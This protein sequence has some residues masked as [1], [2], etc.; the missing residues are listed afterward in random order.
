MAKKVP[1]YI[2]G[3]FVDS[4]TSDWIE[5]TNPATNEVIAHCPVA[6]PE[7]IE[8]AI[9]S[10][11]AAQAEWRQVPV[12]ERARYIMR[13]QALL[14]EHQEDIARI[15]A[16]ETGKIMADAMGDVWRGIE[17]VEHAMGIPTLIM[18]ETV[19][20]VAR[21]VDTISWVHPLGVCAGITPFNFPA[22]IPLWMFPLAVVCG[23]SF[24][25]K[26]SEQ[27]PL[28]PMRLAELW[29]EAGLP[30]GL[31]QIVHGRKEQVEQII[32]HPDIKAVSFVGSAPVGAHIYR[33]ATQH[34][35]RAQCMVGAKNH[36]VIMPDAN[37]QQVINN[38]VGAACGAAGQ[39]CM[40]IS[41]AVLVGEETRDWVEDIKAAMAKLRPGCR[42]TPRPLTARSSAAPRWSGWRG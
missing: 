18:G 30:P 2:D 10:A 37:K 8:R 1:L 12:P 11:K 14:K 26:P 17:V 22:M 36:M 25:L 38:L 3:R 31:L 34:L 42:M 6:L 35:K 24:V 39:R 41:V 29:N 19:E 13:Y 7:E 4:E 15:V 28:T 33:T 32:T 5:V 40:A 16:A 23:N 21:G 20:Q 27:D 9:A